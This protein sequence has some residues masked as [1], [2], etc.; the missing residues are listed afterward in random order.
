MSKKKG[1]ASA[2]GEN[3]IQRAK[4][5]EKSSLKNVFRKKN[6]FIPYLTFG[7]P[8]IEISLAM[9]QAAVAA[10]ADILEIGIPFSDPIADGPVIQASH[11]RALTQPVMPTLDNLFSVLMTE[12]RSFTVPIILMLSANLVLHHGID[13][14]FADAAMSGVSGAVIPDLSIEDA[15]LYSHAS[16]KHGVPIV[17]LVSTLCTDVRLKKIVRHADGFLYLISSKGLTGT[18][19][20]LDMTEI[21]SMVSRIKAIK[22]IPVAVG[23]GVKTR[24]QADALWQV[25][26]GVIVG[27]YLVGAVADVA[28]PVS[29][30][31]GLV[32]EF[33]YS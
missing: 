32:G 6:V 8:N 3:G 30:I 22:N 31:S 21:S 20:S 1:L 14:F 29:V 17:F 33:C 2:A 16:K 18:R 25:A 26:D 15:A 24:A 28:D 11:Q 12:G 7:D 9:M 19:D 4:P 23:F 10:G 5:F 27:S 13:R